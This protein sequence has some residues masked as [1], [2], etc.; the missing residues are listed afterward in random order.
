MKIHVF[1]GF[2]IEATKNS[3][4]L[5]E[6]YMG[7]TRKGEPRKGSR[8]IG[9]FS[10]VTQAVRRCLELNVLNGAEAVELWEYAKMVEESNC[11]AIYELEKRINGM[12]G[13]K[14]DGT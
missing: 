13:E 1:E 8:F 9:S 14:T 5:R 10:N 12:N 6:E 3:Y 7:K 2:Y 4:I 11:R